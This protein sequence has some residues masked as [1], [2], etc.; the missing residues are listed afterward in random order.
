MTIHLIAAEVFA[1]ARVA[2]EAG[3]LQAVAGPFDRCLYTGPCAI[4]V[5][6]PSIQ[7]QS[8]DDKELT[9]DV[10]LAWGDVTTDNPG[11]LS[12]LQAA[13]DTLT[14]VRAG[15]GLIFYQPRLYGCRP[16]VEDAKARFEAVL[17]ADI[18]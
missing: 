15:R 18:R 10:L 17:Y 4:G 9:I 16:S 12:W 5:S 8:F 2:Y 11:A 1:K 13:H 7:C 6:L 14:R 3:T